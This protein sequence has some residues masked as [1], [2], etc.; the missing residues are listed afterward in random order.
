MVRL[1][2]LTYL[3]IQNFLHIL[4]TFPSEQ[5][6]NVSRDFTMISKYIKLHSTNLNIEKYHYL[7]E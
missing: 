1:D 5:H 4:I 6:L 7:C 2:L 3:D